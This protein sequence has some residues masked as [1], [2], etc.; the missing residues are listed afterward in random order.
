M[1]RHSL[2]LAA[3]FAALV[4]SGGCADPDPSGPLTLDVWYGDSQRVG[5]LGDAQADF[6]LLGETNARRL[7][8]SLNGGPAIDLTVPTGTFGYRRLG[9][10]GHFNAD[11][12]L[13][14]LRDGANE[15][16][17]TA[18]KRDGT[19]VQEKV[20]LK[21]AHGRAPLPYAIDWEVAGSPQAVGQC[22]DGHWTIEPN[23][24][25]SAFP[26]YDRLFLIG[27]KTWRDYEVSTTFTVHR[28]AGETGPHSGGNGLGVVFRFTGHSVGGPLA[29][30]DAQPRWGYLPF[31]AITWLRW[32]KGAPEEPPTFQF[33][34]G[35][36]NELQDFESLPF[37]VERTYS[38]VASCATLADSAD[39]EGVTRYRLQIWEAS[40]SEPEVR[41]FE[42]IQTS[43]DALRTGGFAFVA[44][45]VDVTFGNVTVSALGAQ[46]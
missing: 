30:P 46:R 8:Y 31:G 11:I 13:V 14:A 39:G 19:R 5:H 1:R 6:N 16:L 21:R 15:V 34:R 22:V 4:A 25:R 18:K 9:G 27:D 38:L 32:R 36:R 23:G 24:L 26:A 35:D 17:L 2:T 29:F 45:H 33:Y 20:I 12:P 3:L 7:E 28:V 40:T 41:A 43:R 44:H 10:P 42:V 37:A